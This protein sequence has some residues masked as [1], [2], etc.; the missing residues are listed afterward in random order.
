MKEYILITGAS[1][2]LG[3]AIAIELLKEKKSLILTGRNEKEL[4]KIK[5]Q[6]LNETVEIFPADLSSL[7][8]CENL[9]NFCTSKGLITEFYNN[10]GLGYFNALPKSDWDHLKQVL[11][12]NIEAFTYLLYKFSSHMKNHKSP[13]R[14]ISISSMT[15]FL[16]VPNFAV[17]SASKVYVRR[18]HEIVEE[19]LKTSA[20]KFHIVY[21]GGMNTGFI[22]ASK[23]RLSS[24]AQ[25]T[26]ATA[27][28]VAKR[29]LKNITQNKKVI[30]PGIENKF[31]YFLSRVF[32]DRFLTKMV[33]LVTKNLMTP[34]T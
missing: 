33:G 2:G 19:E 30:I 8:N 29:I 4:Q 11:R 21:P 6:F 27:E 7:E 20:I 14:I 28:A 13:S 12:V 10:A 31:M 9:Y 32:G 26:L 24:Q 23:Q 22:D 17:Y 15:A 1:S 34:S 18:I 25:K 5:D 16:P 3:K